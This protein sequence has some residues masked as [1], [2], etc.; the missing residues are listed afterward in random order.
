MVRD[1]AGKHP[2]YY[3][4]V[5]QLR[6]VTPEIIGFVYQEIDRIGLHIAKEVHLE[7]GLDL[8]LTDKSLT[9]ALGKIITEKN[10]KCCR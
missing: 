7:G 1:L 8:R 9:K 2:Q 3:E 10:I 4:A 5:L 6:E